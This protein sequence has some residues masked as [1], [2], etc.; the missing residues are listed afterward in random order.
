MA[1]S[2]LW[3]GNDDVESERISVS[4]HQRSEYRLPLFTKLL[5][6]KLKN[7][8]QVHIVYLASD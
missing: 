2:T 7:P 4:K 1:H 5:L 3:L 6:Y 8:D